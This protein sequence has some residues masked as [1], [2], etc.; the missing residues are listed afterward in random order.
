[1]PRS[2]ISREV[3]FTNSRVC[4]TPVTS[5]TSGT[6]TSVR[7]SFTRKWTQGGLCLS[8]RVTLIT[9]PASLMVNLLN[10]LL[11]QED[12]IQWVAL[13]SMLEVLMTMA[14]LLT[15]LRLSRSLPTRT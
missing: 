1:M 5:A 7:I 14:M 3:V 10:L 15:S 8:Y 13:V 2:E 12:A 9:E 11:S 6:L 4:G